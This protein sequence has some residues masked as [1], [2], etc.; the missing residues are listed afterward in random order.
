[1]AGAVQAVEL[2]GLPYAT[3]DQEQ[4]A[5]MVRAGGKPMDLAQAEEANKAQQDLSYVAG[6]WGPAGT[7]GMGVAS[8]LTLGL[9]PGA[10]AAMGIV[11]P[12]HLQAAQTSGLYTAGDV[13]G[14]VLPALLSGGESLAG[15]SAVG[16]ALSFT[17]AGLMGSAGNLSERIAMG[18]LGESAG[19][20]GRAASAPLRMA[21]RGATEGALMNIGHTIGH[22]LTT[23]HP[24][25]A[26]SIAASGID[27]ALFGGLLGG[28][29]G[30]VG[31]LGGMAIERAGGLVKHMAG[32]GER[33]AGM[34]G[35]ELG[36]S[37]EEL[38]SLRSGG[39]ESLKKTMVE[40]NA[41]LEKGGATMGSTSGEKLEAVTHAK[42][43]FAADRAAVV[44]TLDETA[45]AMAPSV[46]RVVARAKS[47]ILAPAAGTAS[48]H[49]AVKA[50]DKFDKEIDHMAPRV[51]AMDV[52]S[53][54]ENHQARPI[55][56]KPVSKD[57][58]DYQQSQSP[59]HERQ[60][61]EAYKQTVET[62]NSNALAKHMDDYKAYT[63]IT[64]LQ[65]RI[66]PTWDKWVQS[67]DSIAKTLSSQPEVRRQILNIM[68]DE[69]RVHMVEAS[70]MAGLEG[71]AEKYGAATAGQ[72]FA[73]T[74]EDNIGKKHS[75]KLL[76]SEHAITPRDF[77]TFVGMSA[78]SHP[79]SGLAWLLSKGIG[80]KLNQRLEPTF[81][82]TAYNNMIGVKASG[83]TSNAAS[84][85][86]SGL[87]NFLRSTSN[88]AAKPFQVGNAEK[89]EKKS[90]RARGLDRAGYESAATNA[91]QLL[92]SAHQ[93]KVKRYAEELNSEGY[94][95]LAQ[96]IIDVNQRAVQYQTWNQP[97]RA[98]TKAMGT[99]RK[100]SV[101]KVPTM[102]E[103][104]FIRQI[105]GIQGSKGK[106]PLSTLMDDFNNGSL[107]RDQVRAF[108]YVYPELKNQL[109]QQA[110]QIVYEKKQSGETLPMDKVVTLGVL[111]DT[112]IDSM[113]QPDRVA[114]IQSAL[115]Y[116]PQPSARPQ[117]QQNS[118]MDQVSVNNELKTPLQKVMS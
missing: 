67:R 99:L 111:L 17:P 79:V 75:A 57:V 47:D 98:A 62:S 116:Q 5:S 100:T 63:K 15:R 49:E 90:D 39:A 48:E 34:V 58:F 85:I 112:P 55:P 24:L 82:Q 108:A 113:L 14:T 19:L 104:K 32:T 28:T 64:E 117:P 12:G 22:D 74:L 65:P 38:Q 35:R 61:Y 25:T 101:S 20:L 60:G 77:G 31:S 72:T 70:K 93:N 109:V 36:Y 11:D 56:E 97:P 118:T 81:A 115:S 45:P 8:G 42:T 92:S 50:L 84:Q 26:E 41:I 30:A 102:Q 40:A 1:M 13:A 10:L 52:K 54:E 95:E 21:A 27:G 76:S 29:V 2:G 103:S 3:P 59:L 80:R 96:S 71:V 88:A 69:I 94:P 91:E 110:S 16:R 83:A 6:N 9:G 46:D 68:D 53:W 78:I 23:N 18:T 7:A 105:R 43:V 89:Y 51:K 66:T 114:A 107:S 4:A 73:K 86:S 106:S 37:A 87:R 44:K 33:A